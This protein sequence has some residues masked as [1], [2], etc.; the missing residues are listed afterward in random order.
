MTIFLG[1]SN[2]HVALHTVPAMIGFL[3]SP[4]KLSSVKPLQNK[5]IPVL[6]NKLV[7]SAWVMNGFNSGHFV[8]TLATRRMHAKIVLT[9]DVSP[10]GR[11]IF[12]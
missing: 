11:A 1:N 12:K 3:S 4:A 2:R 6:P 7:K 5:H 9:T 8:S 10:S